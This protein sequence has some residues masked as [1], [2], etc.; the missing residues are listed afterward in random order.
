M[1]VIGHSAGGHL[2]I[3]VSCRSSLRSTDP[4][5]APQVQPVAAVSLAGV[6]DLVAAAG[7]GLGAG[8]VAELLGG[9]RER[10]P[11]RDRVASPAERLP[12]GVAHLLV[13][14]DRDPSVPPGY[15]RRHWERARAAGDEVTLAIQPGAGHFE[16]IDPGHPAG[17]VGIEW[18]WERLVAPSR[19]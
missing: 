2:A 19:P 10:E 18:L 16:L 4:G 13:H 8:A 1:G 15:S 9:A 12:I 7:E 17:R 5:A 6:L 3:W 11:E 14:G